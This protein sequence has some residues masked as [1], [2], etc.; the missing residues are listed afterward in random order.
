MT[1]LHAAMIE[2]F[3]FLVAS[4]AALSMFLACVLVSW[5]YLAKD[6]L[7]IRMRQLVDDREVIRVRERAKLHGDKQ[8]S[9]RTEPK[10]V[11]KDIFDR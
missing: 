7:G 3:D 9:L 4:M 1:M 11:F 8:S 2:H 5:P 10:K 6:A